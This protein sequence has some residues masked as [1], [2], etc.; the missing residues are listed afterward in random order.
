MIQMKNY[1]KIISAI[2]LLINGIGAL[3]GG[4]NLIAHPDG[5]SIDL[6]IDWLKHSPFSNYL[7]PGIILFFTNGL[8][9]IVVLLALLYNHPKYCWLIIAE[10]A[11]LTGWIIIQIQLIQTVYFLHFV[12]GGIGILLIISGY[13]L[14]RLDDRLMENNVKSDN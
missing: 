8:A 5:S 14:L 11:L 6:S 10:G 3:Y 1:L 4:W 2:L 13:M 9:S 7:I 12:M